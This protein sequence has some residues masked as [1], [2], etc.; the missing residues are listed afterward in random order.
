MG[1]FAYIDA[2][3]HLREL[4]REVAKGVFLAKTGRLFEASN[5]YRK[6]KA[7]R[8][9]AFQ[10]FTVKYGQGAADDWQKMSAQML[11]PLGHKIEA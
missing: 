9:R 3:R 8:N 1:P 6:A 7:E 4:N 2:R 5:C 11:M 10:Y